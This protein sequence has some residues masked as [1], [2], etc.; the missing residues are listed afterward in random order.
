MGTIRCQTCKR[1]GPSRFCDECAEKLYPIWVQGLVAAHC[2]RCGFFSLSWE[3]LC[4]YW[5]AAGE[6]CDP[7]SFNILMLFWDS[8]CVKCNR[9]GVN[10]RGEKIRF[11]L[12]Q[13]SRRSTD[14][15]AS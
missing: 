9:S 3:D 12:I 4:A 8:G 2:P 10:K 11:D 15:R 13:R 1:E 6:T 7:S 14:L 5:V